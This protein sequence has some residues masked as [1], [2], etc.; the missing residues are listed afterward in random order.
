MV[1]MRRKSVLSLS[2]LATLL[3][4][5]SSSLA[6]SQCV[7]SSS[8]GQCGPYSDSQITESNGSNAHVE[9]DEWDDVTWSQ[10]LTAS[11]PSNWYMSADVAPSTSRVSC[12]YTYQLYN[13]EVLSSLTNIVA[14]FNETSDHSSSTEEQVGLDIYLNNWANEVQM[15]HDMVN[16][17]QCGGT[18]PVLT[19]VEFGGTYGVSEESW[20]QCHNGIYY[21]QLPSGGDNTYDLRHLQQE[22]GPHRHAQLPGEPR[23]RAEQQHSDRGLVRLYHRHYQFDNQDLHGQQPFD[24]QQCF[25]QPG[26]LRFLRPASAL[27]QRREARTR[28]R[29]MSP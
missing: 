4:L 24:N 23:I 2:S 3:I 9:N 20:D 16:T 13:G 28:P 11:S 27:A 6:W 26:P 14:S 10:T 18:S 7:T 25:W 1:L 5:A 8:T 22:R 29:K 17:S 19:G 12:P 21:W 15:Q